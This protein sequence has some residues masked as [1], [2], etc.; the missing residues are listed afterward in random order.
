MKKLSILIIIILVLISCRK[1]YTA[2]SVSL[3]NK[4]DSVNY[5][6][7]LVYG[8]KL[9]Q[10]WFPNGEDS[11]A[12]TEFI[13]AL[14]RGYEG[15]A[16]HLSIVASTGQDI[17]Y[18][19]QAYEKTGIANN[20]QW[21]INQK[22]FFQGLVN[23][24][25][26]DTVVMNIDAARN[27]IQKQQV[28]TTPN[29]EPANKIVKGKCP[30]KTK[31]IV[32]HTYNDSINF[33]L[34][35]IT[36]YDMTQDFLLLDNTGRMREELIANINK[37][38]K[39]KYKYPRLVKIGEEI[40]KKIKD[41]ETTGLIDEIN[42]MTNFNIIKQGFINGLLSYDKQMTSEA[43]DDY[44]RSI[45]YEK[46]REASIKFMTANASREGVITTSSGLQY[47]VLK[48]GKGAVPTAIDK[49]KVHY[50]GTLL[51]GTIFASSIENEP[52]TIELSQTIAGWKE[53]LQFMPIG[54]KFRL[55]VPQELGYGNQQVGAIPPFSTLIFEVELLGI[56]K[57][58]TATKNVAE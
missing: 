51:D 45:K 23:A 4:N 24:I 21:V 47:E 43:A 53:A 14:Q 26:Y 20:P 3:T 8:T 11:D 40:G 17:G 18:T 19:A 32:L 7:G 41:Q 33:T 22:I 39:S 29:K 54:S 25:Y 50:H 36:G 2:Q 55:F 15:K 5:A 16:K 58:N 44:I 6:L 38:L 28:T 52:I 10:E 35:Y 31:K 9:K 37:A 1:T 13:D 57:Q 30:K 12:V 49:V 56:E 34:G 42:L 48:K 27:Y 46:V